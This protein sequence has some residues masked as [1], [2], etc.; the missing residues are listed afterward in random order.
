VAAVR[1][2]MAMML[3]PTRSATLGNV[4]DATVL[5]LSSGIR[6]EHEHSDLLRRA[7][8]YPQDP[9]CLSLN[10]PEN[11]RHFGTEFG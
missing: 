4:T 11:G 9:G 1:T 3:P 10:L 6:G 5:E 8:R 2:F 7:E